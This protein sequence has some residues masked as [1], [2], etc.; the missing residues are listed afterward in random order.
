MEILIIS[1]VWTVVSVPLSYLVKRLR[2]TSGRMEIIL[3]FVPW[4]E[5]ESCLIT[6][7]FTLGKQGE[8]YEE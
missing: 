3:S 2:F 4:L 5:I 8:I 6:E 7:F 1:R